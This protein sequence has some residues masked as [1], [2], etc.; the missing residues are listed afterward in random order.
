LNW[1]LQT[2]LVPASFKIS[3]LQQTEGGAVL[4]WVSEPGRTYRLEYIDDLRASG[5]APVTG[6]ITAT[7]SAASKVDN[8]AGAAPRRFYRVLLLP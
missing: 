8:T 2:G 5:W 1:H 6:D 7:F 3:S 4:A